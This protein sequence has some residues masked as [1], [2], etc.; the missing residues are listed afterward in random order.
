MFKSA[1]GVTGLCAALVGLVAAAP[2]SADIVY[3]GPGFTKPAHP[4]EKSQFSPEPTW[5]WSFIFSDP[6]V[7]RTFWR[8]SDGMN[9]PDPAMAFE[10]GFA[11]ALGIADLYYVPLKEEEK[12]D[13]TNP[14]DNTPPWRIDE[15]YEPPRWTS[16]EYTPLIA[17][18]VPEPSTWAMIG[19]G[20]LA[21]AYLARRRG[22]AGFDQG[23]IAQGSPRAA[24]E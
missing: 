11:G 12:K 1:P 18:S 15:G 2:A 24:S 23:A 6:R 9:G 14:T 21:L 7:R 8:G 16:F 5:T 17:D 3:E 19:A 13:E 20:F 22:Y 4:P 10:V